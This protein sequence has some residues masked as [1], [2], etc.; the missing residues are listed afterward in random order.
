MTDKNAMEMAEEARG[1]KSERISFAR[2]LFSGKFNPSIFFPYPEQDPEDKAVGDAYIEEMLTFLKGNLDPEEIEISREIPKKVIDG[3]VDLGAFALKV[4]KEYGGLGFSQTNYNRLIQHIASYCGSTAVLLS[5]HQSI[6]VPQPLKMYG[7]EEQK[8]KYFPRFRK[9]S[10][11]AFALTE[12]EVGSDPA[13]MTSTA[14]LSEDG[15]HYIL[16]GTKLWCTNGTIADVIVVMAKTAP[17]VIKGK[18]RPQI[19][20]FILEMDSPGVEVLHRCEFMGLAGI[21]NGVLKFTDVKIP[22]ENRLGEEGRGLAM[23][24]ETINVG[25]LT[26]PAASVGVA[27]QCLSIARRWG[28]DRVQWGMPVGLHEAGREKLSY[29]AA[30]TFAME[31]VANL[32]GHWQDLGNFD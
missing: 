8:K 2:E 21:Y 22:V 9:G 14:E 19:S 28:R 18:E 16:N 27:K 10:I 5:A 32:T 7:T 6:G 20:S 23:A 1:G 13:K 17:K 4:P 12:P 31:A 3:L 25:R 24:L 29:I 11:S 26:L 30:T 15:S